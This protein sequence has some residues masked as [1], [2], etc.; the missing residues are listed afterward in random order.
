MK[1]KLCQEKAKRRQ[2]NGGANYFWLFWIASTIWWLGWINVFSGGSNVI[3]KVKDTIYLPEYLIH[4]ENKAQVMSTRESKSKTGQR[5]S[6][7]F[8]DFF[9]ASTPGWFGW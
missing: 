6:K 8:F 4:S 9:A 7:V 3:Y 1:P 2:C 5:R